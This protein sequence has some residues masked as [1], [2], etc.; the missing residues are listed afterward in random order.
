[1]RLL[2]PHKDAVRALAREAMRLPPA[3]LALAA[4]PLRTSL[5]WMLAAARVEP[6]GALQPLQLKGLGL[7]YLSVLR[8]WLAD[9]GEDQARTMAALDKALSR[10]DSLAGRLRPRRS[11]EAAAEA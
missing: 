6:W 11:S 10:A 3:G 8:V 7:V 9:D 4:G 1:M 2:R 5:Q